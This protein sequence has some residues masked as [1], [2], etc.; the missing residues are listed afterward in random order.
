MKVPD[1]GNIIVMNFSPTVGH[2]Q[3]GIRPAIVVTPAEFNEQGLA[4]VCPITNTRRGHFFEIEVRGQKTDG[5]ALLYNL[6]SI[7]Y[8]SRGAKI[9]DKVDKKTLREILDK[10]KI[11]LE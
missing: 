4:F 9:V 5:V 2:E 7:D 10:V 8:V 3:S 6:R 1:R 11:I